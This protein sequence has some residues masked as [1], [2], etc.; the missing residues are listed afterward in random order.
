MIKIIKKIKYIT[1]HP[2]VK[3][4]TTHPVVLIKNRIIVLYLWFKKIINLDVNFI[5]NIH[6]E[7]PIDVVIVAIDKDFDVLVHV[8]DSIRNNVMH[9]IGDIII[10]SPKSEIITNLCKINK[11]IFIDENTVLPIT[12]KDINYAVAGVDRSG[13]LFQQLLKWSGDNYS[14]N[15]HFL[16]ADADSVFCRPQLFIDNEKVILAVSNQLCH[17]PY[18]E[19]YNKLTGDKIEPLINFTS[20]HA[21]FQKSKLTALKQKIEKHCGIEWYRAII[22]NI[23]MQE[24][25]AVSDYETYGQ[26]VFSNYADEYILEHWFNLS[27]SRSMLGKISSTLKKN[28]NKYK[29]ISF[30]TYK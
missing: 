2:I 3:Y 21:L 15:D 4:Y 20:H 5:S 30:H 23:D 19:A 24:G 1:G 27:L 10:I 17:I 22:S 25:S 8:V 11:C 26:F 9:P 13:W 28:Y 16:V 18:F 29:T 12:K 6:S 14:K 7:I